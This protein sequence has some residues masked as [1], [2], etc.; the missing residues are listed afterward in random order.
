MNAYQ[1]VTNSIVSEMEKGIIPWQKPF[2]GPRGSRNYVS[3]RPYS[4]LNQML[5]PKAGE[6]LTPKQAMDAGADFTGAK[7]SRIYFFRVVEK[8]TVVKDEQTGEEKTVRESYPVLKDYN[9]LH[10][11]DCRG[12]EPRIEAPEGGAGS[13]GDVDAEDI[14]DAFLARTGVKLQNG[15]YSNPS[16]NP[17]TDTVHM[18]EMKQYTSPEAYYAD[19]FRALAIA[20]G[21]KGRLDRG[22]EEAVS[23]EGAGREQLVGE[24]TAAL[25]LNDLE[26]D[27]LD[28]FRNS[29]AYIQTWK[30]ALL[31]DDHM[32]VW[33]AGRA[34]KAADYILGRSGEASST[35]AA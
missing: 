28:V 6:W 15:V 31:A 12:L 25:L 29:V 32:I 23:T 33:A 3:R 14:I 7:A 8:N 35:A 16:Y 10:V 2:Q 17:A 34:E 19:L 13:C 20:T 18:P 30:E 24:I 21:T 22:V 11:T 27:T 26:M 4:L 9:V 5:L 1:Q